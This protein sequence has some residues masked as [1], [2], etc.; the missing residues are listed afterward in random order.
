[1]KA[2]CVIKNGIIITP[3]GTII[4]GVAVKGTQIIAVAADEILPDA[5]RF[6]DAHGGYVIPGLIDIH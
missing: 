6:V 4:G 2:D 5:S 1:M 3:Q